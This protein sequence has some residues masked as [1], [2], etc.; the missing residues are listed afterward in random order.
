ML[1]MIWPILATDSIQ[2]MSIS[3][4][5]RSSQVGITTTT[6]NGRIRIESA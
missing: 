1:P 2:R 3:A 6:T 5:E 4:R